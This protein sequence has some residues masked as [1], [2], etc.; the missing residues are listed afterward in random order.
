MRVAVYKNLNTGKWSVASVKQTRNGF[1]KDKLIKHVDDITLDNVTFVVGAESTRQRIINGHREV[2][3][4]AVGDIAD[5]PTEPC[6]VT[7]NVHF[8]P[9]KA[10]DFVSLDDDCG[11]GRQVECVLTHKNLERV[12][13]LNGADLDNNEVYAI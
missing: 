11:N 10:N 2:Y 9:F 3:A 13:F 7:Y 4:Y 6:N 8:N 5:I 12:Y 1:R